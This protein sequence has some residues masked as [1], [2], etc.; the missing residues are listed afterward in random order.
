MERLLLRQ[1]RD[2]DLEPFSVMNADPE[3]M[4]HFPACLSREQSAESMERQR[5]AIAE[6]GWGFWVV[7]VDGQFAGI[8]GLKLATFPAPFTPC[9]EIGWR[10]R[11]EFWG[12]G[13]AF[14]A[15]TEALTFGFESLKLREI[16][17][18]TAVANARSRRLME[19][20][21]F[22]RS[23]AEDFDHPLVPEGNAARRH[24]LY[25]LAQGP[26][27]PSCNPA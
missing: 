25:R 10:F 4:R 5:C 23:P 18:F 6:Q 17:A 19:R 15:A 7:E 3:V 14:R 16:L 12:R 1:W 9:T 27:R 13:L 26:V 24:V 2:E 8:T 22:R 11:R 21:G 20:L